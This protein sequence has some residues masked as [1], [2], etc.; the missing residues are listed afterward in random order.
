M[1]ARA[2]SRGTP[3]VAVVVLA[4]LAATAAIAQTGDGYDLS[5][6]TIGG[7]GTSMSAA[8][9]STVDGTAGQPDAGSATD[10]TYSVSG[11]FWAGVSA[12]TAASCVGDC[13]GDGVVTVNEIIIGVNIALGNQT[14]DQCPSFD[15]NG[16]GAVTV[17]E[18][19]KAVNNA[20]NG[21]S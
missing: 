2:R 7:G 18:L 15:A 3:A 21:C 9:A 1:I 4:W 8:D 13:N 14:L 10:G 20:L 5:W 11:G 6:N 19:I 16:N 17:D 12:G